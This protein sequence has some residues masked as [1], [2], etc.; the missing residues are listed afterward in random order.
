MTVQLN[1]VGFSHAQE[2]VKGGKVD[3][4][5]PWSFG[6]DDESGL[7]G[8]TPDWS[9]YSQ[10]FL[11]HDTGEQDDTKGAWKYP[12]GKGGK[13]YRAALI[14]IRQ[15]ASAQDATGIFDAAGRL[16]A[17]MDGDKALGRIS[18]RALASDTTEITVYGDIGES[19]DGSSTTALD[20]LQQVNAIKTPK[21]VIRINSEGGSVDDGLAIVNA[22]KRSPAEITAVVDGVA[23]SSASLICMGADRIEMSPNAL[24]MLHAPWGGAFGNATQFR[25]FADQLDKYALAM[26]QDYVAKTKQPLATV[27]GWL[28]GDKDYWF[29]AQEAV[30]E[31]LADSIVE[32]APA[33]AAEARP[34]LSRYMARAPARIAAALT[35][36][37]PLQE[38]PTMDPKDI[39]PEEAVKNP[40]VVSLVETSV[41][42]KR[43]ERVNTI[44]AALKPYMER[45]GVQALYVEAIENDSVSVETVQAKVMEILGKGAAP[46]NH[47]GTGANIEVTET[48][49]D[50]RVKAMAASLVARAGKAK[51]DGANDF[52]GSRL[53]D[54][55]RASLEASGSNLRG[56]SPLEI[57]MLALGGRVRGAQTTSDFPVVLENTLHKLV[58]TGFLAAPQTWQQW[59]KTGSVSDFREWNRIVPGVI[60]NLDVVNENGEY[61]DKMIPDGTKNPVSAQRRGNI[62]RITPEVIVNDDLGY[63]TTLCSGLGQAGPR[64]I[65]RAAYAV[66]VANPVLSDGVALFHATHGNL[67]SGGGKAAPS[68]ATLDTGR[69]A[70]S[71]QKLPGPDS[72]YAEISPKIA[73]SETTVEGTMRG[74]LG[75]T[76]DP[77]AG[78][79]QQR[80]NIVANLCEVQVGSPRLAAGSWYMFADPEQYP[81][82]EVVFLNGQQEPVVMQEPHF[83]TGGLRYRIELPFGAGAVDFRGAW[84]NPGS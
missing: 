80:T 48:E 12:F 3:K 31:G 57:A 6:A 79:G 20:F 53:V 14:A 11:G 51:P 81:V 59:C 45:E 24:M 4:D 66:L 47:S 84:F 58:M 30:A 13:V 50:K 52:R 7:L 40:K 33:Q 78:A 49:G 5:S 75:S 60:G 83:D 70:M 39:V 71:K 41:N 2:L 55:A 73:L 67:A 77:T 25:A 42:A 37:I 15:R 27:M 38:E 74:I 69:Q 36:P 64:A 23:A 34:D 46:G 29:T 43:T 22:M 26:A 63:I 68:V 35:K 82:I 76:Y 19:W 10:M 44:K 28:G 18:V 65:N 61:T 32:D 8:E 1:S 21:A 16:I 17:A 56:Y 62:V 72:D 54:L 9:A